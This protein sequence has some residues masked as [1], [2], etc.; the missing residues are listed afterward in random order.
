MNSERLLV[1]N[2]HEAWVYQ[3][4]SLNY[5]LDIIDG[6][7]GRYT[8]TWDRRM[9]P[10]PS[11][12]RL[13]GLEDVLIEKNRYTC[14]ITHNISDLMDVKSVPGPRILVMHSTFNWKTIKNEAQIES[15]DLRLSLKDYM[16]SIGGHI[17]AVSSLK[18]NSW[19]FTQDIVPFSADVKEYP[20]WSGDI[21]C[22]LR[23]ANQITSKREALMWDFHEK[24][25]SGIPVRLVGYNPDMSG[26]YPASSWDEL[27]LFLSRHRFFIHTAH[28]E[29][30]DG[31]NMATL[32]AM[33]A[34]LPVLGNCHPT[35]PIEHGISGFLS[36]NPDELK[37]YAILLLNDR[38]LAKKM[39]EK[40]RETVAK[41]FSLEIFVERFRKSI[42]I[43]K[44]KWERRT[45]PDSYFTLNDEEIKKK[46]SYLRT[47]R[48]LNKILAEFEETIKLNDIK[49]AFDKL[50]EMGKILG[51]NVEAYTYDI[52]DFLKV[53]EIIGNCLIEREEKFLAQRLIIK[54]IDGVQSAERDI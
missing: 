38:D 51:V 12:A 16:D 3:L 1:F 39:G 53:S 46:I 28:P 5:E 13:V 4:G 47:K 50:T 21:A 30:E 22:G 25:F 36:D 7:P 15:N 33:A 44:K 10:V 6:L 23:V 41:N 34:G 48:E 49:R 20:P 14:I 9:R 24:A 17:V 31:Y 43:A 32:E 26:V 54:A 2:C 8:S 11:N 35:T 42:E 45:L 19:G 18:G 27:K 37:K 40:A 52:K 29:L